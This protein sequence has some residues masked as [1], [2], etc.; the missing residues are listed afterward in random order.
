MTSGGSARCA[1]ALARERIAAKL[2]LGAIEHHDWG[3][4]TRTV[5]EK[6]SE[7]ADD[8]E[9]AERIGDH[10]AWETVVRLYNQKYHPGNEVA[11]AGDAS[12]S[13]RLHYDA[14]TGRAYTMSTYNPESK[15][16]Y[17]RIGGRWKDYFVYREQVPGLIWGERS[18]D[19]P[20][21]T[22]VRKR[23]C[24]GGPIAALDFEALRSAEAR[25]A[26]KR[27]DR[28]E[29]IT[30]ARPPATAWE[31]FVELAKLGELT[32][33]EARHRYNKQPVIVAATE[34]FGGW[35]DCPVAEFLP[36]REEYVAEA[37]RGAVPRLRPGDARTGL[38]RARPDGVVRHVQ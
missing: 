5:Q 29:Q 19:S 26:G 37:R 36:P 31:H 10:P 32:W 17:W 12:D 1:V 9:W 14:E 27:Y 4:A 30:A 18:W 2:P 7:W 15:W 22:H 6:A 38:G 25:D 11:V 13:E 23:R 35:G 3:R 16:D 34:E 24:D 33:D 28:W 21:P 20:K 8:A